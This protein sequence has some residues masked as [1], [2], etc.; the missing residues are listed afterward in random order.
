MQRSGRWVYPRGVIEPSAPIVFTGGPLRLYERGVWDPGEEYWGELDDTIA[1]SL[2]QVIAAGRRGQFEFEQLLPG[3]D[4]PD[5]DDP[6]LDAID[7]RNSGDPGSA[8]GALEALAAWDARCLDA[9][10]HLGM[11][12]FAEEDLERA[13][14]HYAT[15]VHIAERSLSEG[16]AGVL[17]WGWIDN[18]PFLRCLHGL[19][20]TAWRLDRHDQ[21]ETLCWAL[22]WLNPGDNQGARDLLPEITA[23][24]PWHR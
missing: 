8:R 5:A 22:L 6:I 7:L 11:L 24:A 12:A 2:A 19:T 21:A 18:R 13:L 20:I 23:G 17:P 16:F 4:D 1:V 3:G 15:G 10:A 9:H 14:T